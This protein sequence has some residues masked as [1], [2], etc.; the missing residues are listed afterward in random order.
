MDENANELKV[1]KKSSVSGI[2]DWVEEIVFA[3]VIIAVVFTFV[4]RIITVDGQSMMPT[5]EHGDKVLVTPYF[6]S[7]SQGD[8]VIVVN[9]LEEP[10]IKRVIATEGQT[11][12]FD[13]DAKEVLIDGV[14]LDESQ[15]GLPQGITEVPDYPGMVLEFPQVVPEG[16]V[17][18]M[19]D[20]RMNS[21]D[22]RFTSIGMVDERNILGKVFLYLF[23]FSKFGWAK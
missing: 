1:E 10:I 6:T 21:E 11:V 8:V 7:V 15:F 14:P 19:G 18:V 5:Y 20:N 9:E 23:P 17:F 2:L 22:S 16:S 13:P 3:L 12:D 4:V